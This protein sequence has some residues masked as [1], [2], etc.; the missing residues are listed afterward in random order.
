MANTKERKYVAVRHEG[1]TR[2]ITVGKRIPD[3]WKLVSI[4][5][6]RSKTPDTITL[7]LKRLQ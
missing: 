5:V 7:K 4:E 3:D 6:G 1:N 2:V